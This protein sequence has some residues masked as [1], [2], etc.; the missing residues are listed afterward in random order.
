MSAQRLIKR[1]GKVAFRDSITNK[2]SGI[3]GYHR[4]LFLDWELQL[5]TDLNLRYT[6][7]FRYFTQRIE[8][9]TVPP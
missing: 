2:L 1:S 7:T 8:L 5:K 3:I 4:I 9:S 6:L